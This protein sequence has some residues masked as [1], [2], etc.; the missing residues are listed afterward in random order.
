MDGPRVTSENW[1]E[2]EGVVAVDRATLAA[3][4]I[5]RETPLRDVG[6]DGQIEHVLPNGVVTGRIIAVQIKSGPSHW[7]R[8]N[9]AVVKVTPE[10]KHR[11]YWERHPLPVIVVLHDE[12]QGKTIWTDARAQLRRGA[13]SIEVPL[14]SAFDGDGV[15]RALASDGPLPEQRR[16][17]DEVL[18][19]MATHRHPNPGFRLSFLDLFAGGMTDVAHSL[20]FGMDLVTET[21]D[22]LAVHPGGNG[23]ISI[24]APEYAFIDDYVAFLI[25]RDLARV[26]FDAWRRMDER[27]QMTGKWVTPLTAAGEELVARVSELYPDLAGVLRERSVGMVLRD[28]DERVAM[29]IELADRLLSME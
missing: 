29:Q 26:D 17:A 5:W 8:R 27:F 6:I 21:Q 22:V 14:A 15:K 16:S 1:T 25:A 2:R 18:K 4:A 9:S 10:P 24:G 19:E 28:M 13:T 11:A 23:Q 20:Y 12:Q 7:E 3:R